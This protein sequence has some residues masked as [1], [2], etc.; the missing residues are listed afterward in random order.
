MRVVDLFAGLGGMTCGAIEA[1]AE[2]VLA[3]DSDPT[4]LKVL[5]ANAPQT[6]IIVATLGEGRDEVSLPPAAPDLHVHLSTP[7]TEI[8]VA[9]RGT[10]ADTTGGLQMIRWA[11][12]FALDRNE[13]SWSLENVPTKATRALM[14]ELVAANPKRVAFGVF[15]SADFGAPQSR[16][17]LI[18]GPPEVIRMLQGI[19]YARRVSVRDAFNRAGKELPA[20]YCKNQTRSQNGRPTM[21]GVETQSFTVCAGHALTWCDADGKTVSVMTARDSAILM[22][23]PLTYTLPK[24]S[25]A[26]QRAVG[27]A[28]CVALSKAIVLAAIAVQKGDT[29]VSVET[30]AVPE[31]LPPPPPTKKRPAFELSHRQYRRL[32]RRVEALE[33]GTPISSTQHGDAL[34]D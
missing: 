32:L 9:R 27:N 3:V 24:G 30:I 14:A 28:M 5:G 16:R 11:V 33:G 31:A 4:P 6:T 8:S 10:S 12:S 17:R 15:D 34:L 29:A 23:F 22:G 19:P 1:G 18:A 2:V 26:A 20:A 13:H 25:R 21:R 7:C